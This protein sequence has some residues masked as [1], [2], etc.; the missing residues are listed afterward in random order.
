[1]PPQRARHRHATGLLSGLSG[2]LKTALL[3]AQDYLIAV[4]GQ[5]SSPERGWGAAWAQAGCPAARRHNLGHQGIARAPV[6]YASD[7]AFQSCGRSGL[8]RGTDPPRTTHAPEDTATEHRRS[9]PGRRVAWSLRNSS[10]PPTA[11]HPR[12]G[13]VAAAVHFTRGRTSWTLMRMSFDAFL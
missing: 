2:R 1:M 3:G 4:F 6:T 10:V 5:R 13:Q 8:R 11:R 12:G 9:G 7:A